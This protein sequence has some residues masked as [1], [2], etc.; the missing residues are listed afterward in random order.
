MGMGGGVFN[1]L[2]SL[3]EEPDFF[4]FFP[5]NVKKS[6]LKAGRLSNSVF[7]ARGWMEGGRVVVGRWQEKE[8][9][10]GGKNDLM[11]FRYQLRTNMQNISVEIK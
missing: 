6:V 3:P 11:K 5:A 1:H 4:S 9:R 8:R 2:S 7:K 10:R